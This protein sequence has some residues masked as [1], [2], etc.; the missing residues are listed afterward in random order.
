MA[1][2]HMKIAIL[3]FLVSTAVSCSP[4]GSWNPRFEVSDEIKSFEKNP[5][6][7][8]D[9]WSVPTLEEDTIFWQS[10]ESQ[11]HP[12]FTPTPVPIPTLVPTPSGAQ[13]PE[14]G[15]PTSS[16]S[17]TPIVTMSPEEVTTPILN[18][19]PTMSPTMSP[20]PA[21]V[22]IPIK[23]RLDTERQSK[24]YK[25]LWEVSRK[26][27]L[28]WSH[29]LYGEIEKD[30]IILKANP[31]D[32]KDFC[33]Q[34]EN[35]SREEKINFWGL[36]VSMISKYESGFDPL[37]RYHEKTMGVD[38]VTKLPVHSEGLLQ[39]SYQDS[40]YYKN[41]DFN[42]ELD[43]KLKVKDPKKTILNPE[44]NL[45][46]GVTI[47]SSMLKRNEYLTIGKYQYWAVLHKNSKYQKNK[48]MQKM[49]KD[50][51]YCW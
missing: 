46:C 31:K 26:E 49:F 14:E 45:K 5:I 7:E 16:P 48:E 1:R 50:V 40:K 6:Q 33:P 12:S 3:L 43:K 17:P 39:L 28:Q 44:L 47:L 30:P 9:S 23:P 10:V 36:L 20:T 15:S 29:F 42:W 38:P 24:K 37:V 34:F 32:I 13:A 2:K 18:P 51:S 8:S 41:C 11:P 21:V 27:G 25:L 35:L 4:G 19:T 22:S